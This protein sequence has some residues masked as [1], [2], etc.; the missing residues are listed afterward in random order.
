MDSSVEFRIWDLAHSVDQISGRNLCSQCSV[1]R[2]VITSRHILQYGTI[3]RKINQQESTDMDKY[4]E[5]DFRLLT[6]LV[7]LPPLS[8]ISFSEFYFSK[9]RRDTGFDF[10]SMTFLYF[11]LCEQ[12][13][14]RGVNVL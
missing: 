12:Q 3:G 13:S 6:P 4:T 9:N 7:S 2:S 1:C 8:Q 5:N 14:E 11:N 10:R